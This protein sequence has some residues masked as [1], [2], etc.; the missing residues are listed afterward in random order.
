MGYSNIYNGDFFFF[1]GVQRSEVRGIIV[2]YK[3]FKTGLFYGPAIFFK[4]QSEVFGV[5]QSEVPRRLHRLAWRG[6]KKF[7]RGPVVLRWLLGWTGITDES[8]TSTSKGEKH[9]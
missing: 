2:D 9:A 3:E 6:V 8:P 5:W 1:S 4:D 7:N